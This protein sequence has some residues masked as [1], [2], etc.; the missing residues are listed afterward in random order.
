MFEYTVKE[1]KA[2]IDSIIR[3]YL[4]FA[5]E[6]SLE[7]LSIFVSLDTT[8]LTILGLSSQ[9]TVVATGDEALTFAPQL[10][11]W[12][13]IRELYFGK[14]SGARRGFVV[15]LREDGTVVSTDQNLFRLGDWGNIERIATGEDLIIGILSDGRVRATGNNDYGQ[16]NVASWTDV[17]RIY[18]GKTCVV[19]LRAD[20]TLLVSGR[21]HYNQHEAEEWTDIREV[22]IT[23]GVS[24]AEYI[25][26][27]RGDGTLLRTDPGG[28]RVILTDLLVPTTCISRVFG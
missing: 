9:G 25:Y 16:C 8:P 21:N 13:N 17:V 26:G 2:K 6:A 27:L 7:D 18:P 5:D 10:R 3:Q 19:G 11:Q 28:S 14:Y 4:T 23:Y 1:D 22:Y 15:G 20:G 24:G 12:T